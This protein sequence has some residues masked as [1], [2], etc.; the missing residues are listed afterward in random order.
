MTGDDF[1]VN[2]EQPVTR[3]GFAERSGTTTAPACHNVE[4]DRAVSQP[5][6]MQDALRERRIRN[7][8]SMCKW[9]SH[10]S[11]ADRMAA[12]QVFNQMAREIAGRSSAQIARMERAKG[13]R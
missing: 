11:L 9:L 13:L 1:G 7:H 10:G 2:R 8:A 6:S 3:S 5:V 4:A 12:R